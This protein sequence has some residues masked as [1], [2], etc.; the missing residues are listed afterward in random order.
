M[1]VLDKAKEHFESRLAGEPKAIEVPEWGLTIYYKPMSLKTKGELNKYAENPFEYAARALIARSLDEDGNKLFKGANF[2]EI[3]RQ[4]DPAVVERIVVS[5]ATNE[6]PE[7]V[8][9]N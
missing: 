8:E 4:V 5:M 6:D 3:M 9:K 7:E 1:S 2:T